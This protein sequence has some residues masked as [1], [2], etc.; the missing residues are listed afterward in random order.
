M[1]LIGYEKAHEV[2]SMKD[3]EPEQV[4][5]IFDLKRKEAFFQVES[6]KDVDANDE[7]YGFV[8]A[9]PIGRL[10][11][12]TAAD[13]LYEIRPWVE[14]IE[15]GYKRGLFIDCEDNRVPIAQFTEDAEYALVMMKRLITS[16]YAD[17]VFWISADDWVAGHDYPFADEFLDDLEKAIQEVKDATGDER[18]RLRNALYRDLQGNG[19]EH[20]PYI[21]D[22]EEFLDNA[23]EAT[24]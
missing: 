6:E 5:F 1:K 18:T 2:L 16:Y 24:E 12:R 7:F 22:L 10:L 15:A 20:N 9:Y 3:G 21:Y 8:R 13:L 23:M 17:N 11:P 4:Y 19:A 14:R